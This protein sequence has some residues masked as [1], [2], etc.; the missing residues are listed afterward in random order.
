MNFK[1]QSRIQVINENKYSYNAL[2]DNK[3]LLPTVTVAQFDLALLE[4]TFGRNKY[5]NVENVFISDK[6]II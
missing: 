3:G 2:L 5:F 4:S 1:V 6:P